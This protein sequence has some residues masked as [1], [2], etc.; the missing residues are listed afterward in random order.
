[1]KFFLD[2]ADVEE[3][4][5]AKALGIL[6]GLT[7]NPSLV[8]KTGRKFSELLPEL[9]AL[10]DGPIS[11]EVIATDTQGMIGEAEQL[12][13]VAPNIV[14]KIPLIPD[15]LVA[16]RALKEKG[17]KT[18]VTLC[19]NALQA[20]LAAKAG[21]AYVSPFIGRLDDIGHIGMDIVR[22]I[23]TIFT[24]YKFTTQII[25]ASIRHPLH[26]L[27]AALL[28]ADVATIPFAVFDKL[29]SHPLTDIGLKRFLD[30][31]KKVPR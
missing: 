30:D 16:T 8:S 5:R 6:D 19:F 11:A 2:T 3:I 27:E 23:K 15:G 22:D 18:N 4:K 17:I 9:V 20:L 25:V 13:A 12:A 21:A 14:I 24:N 31:W 26:V 7:T 28:G 29:V 10:V 1:M